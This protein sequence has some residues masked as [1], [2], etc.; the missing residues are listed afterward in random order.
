[1]PRVVYLG[2]AVSAAGYRLAG[3]TVRTP[4]AGEAGQALAWALGRGALVLVSADVAGQIDEAELRRAQL[5]LQP[6]LLVVPDLI[7]GAAAPDLAARLRAQ[8]GMEVTP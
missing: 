3:A 7:G 6:L 2:D 5:A 1:M 4:A 8:L